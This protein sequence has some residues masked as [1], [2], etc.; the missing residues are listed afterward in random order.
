MGYSRRWA[1]ASRGCVVPLHCHRSFVVHCASDFFPCTLWLPFCLLSCS[2]L[3]QLA[4]PR[5]ARVPS[6]MSLDKCLWGM[7][8]CGS[9]TFGA[10]SR[11]SERCAHHARPLSPL[12]TTVLVMMIVQTQ[13]TAH[14]ITSQMLLCSFPTL[15]IVNLFS[16]K[17]THCSGHQPH[18][19]FWRSCDAQTC[20]RS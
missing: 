20:E 8:W 12:V 2:S 19:D 18:E 10:S 16:H 7:P 6:P 4:L 5:C 11:H 9:M 15:R 14:S 13:C 3:L 17:N 1:C